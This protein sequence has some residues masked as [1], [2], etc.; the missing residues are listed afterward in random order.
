MKI[1]GT[2]AKTVGDVMM[3][4]VLSQEEAPFSSET[5]SSCEPED[6]RSSLAVS[7]ADTEHLVALNVL[8]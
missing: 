1:S 8:V 6:Y 5:F 2:D 3:D 7:D 4:S